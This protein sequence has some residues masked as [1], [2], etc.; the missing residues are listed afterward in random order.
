MRNSTHDCDHNN[1]PLCLSGIIVEPWETDYAA[2][3][4]RF[5]GGLSAISSTLII[6]VILRSETR[7]SS[8][9]HRIMFGMSLADICGSIA[10]A[11]TSLPMPSYMPKEEIFGYKW[12]G[13][14]LGNTFT[15]DAQGFFVFFGMGCMFNYNAMLCVYYACAIAFTMRERNI[16]KYVE[17]ILH[18]IPLLAGL[19]FSL[20]PLFYDMYNPSVSAYAW[21]GPV[22][23]PNECSSIPG[24][25]CIRGHGHMLM[26]FQIVIAVVILYVFV[27]IFISL[28]MVLW[29]VIQTDRIIEQI[30]K[31]Y[32]NRGQKDMAKV[33]EK[34]R[35]TKA[36][37]IQ[38]FSYITAFLLGVLPP[39]LLSV[40][41][42]DTSGSNPSEV[43]KTDIFEK[44][45]LV[46]LPLQGFFNF[47][48]FVS[49]K[50]YNYRRVRRDVSIGRV[51][52]LLF[53][54]ST[55][56]PCFISRISIVK[57]H[58]EEENESDD[59]VEC[60]E[61]TEH[62]RVYDVDVKDESNNELHYRLGLM[63]RNIR[64]DKISEDDDQDQSH[65]GTL[66]NGTPS[67]KSMLCDHHLSD[68]ESLNPSISSRT[69]CSN[70]REHQSYSNGS[71]LI[72]FSSRS[73]VMN[74]TL[75]QRDL[76]IDE[77]LPVES[78][79]EKSYYRS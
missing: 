48:I 29:K 73:S 63:N 28:G 69:G 57:Q 59:F 53:C 7:L 74:S 33:L 38:A 41:A 10:M 40:G 23:Y 2:L 56:D 55:H 21:C 46:F 39:L 52:A 22:P 78:R 24:F 67:N 20:P 15:C 43:K 13:A 11:L 35:N 37:V 47:I 1:E 3:V 68:K 62:H 6:Y 4:P 14:R 64:R 12:T 31:L 60:V 79:I 16:K 50:V 49:H 17:P 75:W 61:D 44:I 58:E 66:C 72:S 36:A 27:I 8:I 77:E 54:T 18:G 51:I 65:E 34:H 30:S 25:E 26:T 9:Y 42:V 71:S 70:E 19:S 5:T 32:D 76:S 45:T